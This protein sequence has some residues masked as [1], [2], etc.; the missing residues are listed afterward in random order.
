[1]PNESEHSSVTLID[2]TTLIK[3][4]MKIMNNCEI[5]GTIEGDVDST[6]N[7]ILH[8]EGLIKGNLIS[9]TAEIAGVVLGQVKVLASLTLKES[10]VLNKKFNTSRII[11]HDGAK[12]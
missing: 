12:F 4:N 9:D 5:Y 7:V 6:A 2:S 1:M 10:A 11:I 8:R 3:G